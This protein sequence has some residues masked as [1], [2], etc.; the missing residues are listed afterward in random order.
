MG[1]GFNPGFLQGCRRRSHLRAAATPAV[2]RRQRWSW[3]LWLRPTSL[4]RAVWPIEKGD[5]E[6]NHSK[7]RAWQGKRIGLCIAVSGK[8]SPRDLSIIWLCETG[9]ERFIQ[10]VWFW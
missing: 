5:R 8:R 4:F 7:S 10:G 3:E 6:I 2:Q 9:L 1:S